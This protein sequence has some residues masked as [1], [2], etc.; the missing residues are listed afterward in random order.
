MQ[1]IIS[2]TTL[3]AGTQYYILAYKFGAGAPTAGAASIQF[4]VAFNGASSPTPSPSASASPP[5][6]TPTPTPSASPG[7]CAVINGGL[8]PQPLTESGVAAPAGFFWSEVQHDTGNTTQSNTNAGYNSTQGGGFRLADNF[9]ITQACTIS[10]I[11]FFGYQTGAPATP[12]PFTAYTLQI[13]NGR[14]GDPGAVVV[15]GDTTTN[16]LASS[17]DTTFFRIFNTVVPPPGTPQGTTRKIWRNTV[18]VG[19]VLPAG[20]YWV[21]WADTTTGGANHF[22][23]GKTIAGSRGAAGDNAR[24]FTAGAWVDVTDVGFPAGGTPVPQDF[25]FEVNGTPVGGTPPPTPTPGTPTPTPTPSAS[26]TPCGINTFSNPARHH[27]S[28]MA[29]RARLILRTSRWPA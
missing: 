6:G 28:P 25:P 3:N 7:G 1:A 14:P 19:A 16:R 11:V 27:V 9:T 15:F 22:T 12:S 8:N 21:D 20:S 17:T 29:D 2:N 10:N 4:R 23:P 24:Q 26:P 18:T 13:W 5:S